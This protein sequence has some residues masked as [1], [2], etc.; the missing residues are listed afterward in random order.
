MIMCE[1][2][3]LPDIFGG[4]KTAD[5]LKTWEEI[6]KGGTKAPKEQIEAMRNILAD[7]KLGIYGAYENKSKTSKG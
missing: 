1:G 2:K 3:E 6:N 4:Y 5:L 7:Y